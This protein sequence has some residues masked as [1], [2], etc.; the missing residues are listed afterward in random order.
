V[1]VSNGSSWF[2]S[3]RERERER[4]REMGIEREGRMWRDEGFFGKC[5][6]IEKMYSYS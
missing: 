6:I 1:L 4:E 5:G 3:N 2:S